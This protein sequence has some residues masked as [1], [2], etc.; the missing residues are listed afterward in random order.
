M[1]G[2]KS[3]KTDD[4][5][6][7]PMPEEELAN[8]QVPIRKDRLPDLPNYNKQPQQRQPIWSVEEVPTQVE[9]VI[10]NSK[11]GQSLTLHQ[12]IVEILNSIE[13]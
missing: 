4:E 9:V 3:K 6:D 8:V 12:A 13:D 7:I 10:Y 11:T 5:E 1:F 2:K